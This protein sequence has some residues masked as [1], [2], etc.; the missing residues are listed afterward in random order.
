M[1][2]ADS[3]R[4]QVDRELDP[5]YAEDAECC[6]RH[7]GWTVKAQECSGREDGE[8]TVWGHQHGERMLPGPC[9]V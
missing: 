4:E 1:E 9:C 6:E 3:P 5:S 2:E 7:H 8:E